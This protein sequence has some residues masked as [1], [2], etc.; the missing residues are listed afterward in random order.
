MQVN[1]YYSKNFK[2]K[3]KFQEFFVENFFFKDKNNPMSGKLMDVF[4]YSIEEFDK[5][6]DTFDVILVDDYLID[7]IFENENFQGMIYEKWSLNNRSVAFIALSENYNQIKQWSNY[8]N[9]IRAYDKTELL[10]FL[11]TEIAHDILRFILNE[12]KLKIFISHAKKDGKYIA[13]LMKEFIDSDL[14]LSNFFD[15]VDIQNSDNWQVSLKENIKDKLF[16]YILT[17]SYGHTKWTKQELIWAKELKVPIIGVDVVGKIN[18]SLIPY[19]S[20]TKLVKLTQ[21]VKNIELICKDRFSFLTKHNIRTVINELLKTALEYYLFQKKY[22]NND[23][24]TL[25]RK[26][27]LFD[28][29]N[30][31]K[32]ILYPDPPMMIVEKEV[33]EKCSDKK[34]FTPLTKRIKNTNKKI[35]ISISESPDLEEKGMSIHHLNL[36]MIEIA[37]YLIIQNNTLIYGGDLGYKKEFNF[38]EK[39]AE[40]FHSYNK[41]FG[42]DKKIVNYAAYPFC[43]KINLNIRN[44]FRNVIQFNE[45]IGEDCGF[46]EIDKITKN[47]TKMREII[48]EKMDIKVALGGKITGFS[49][50]YPGVLEEVYLALKSGKS[51][52]LIGGF[53]GIV[54]KIVE[55]LKGYNVEELT[56]EYQKT[57]NEKLD[58][59]LK[60]NPKYE[61]EIKN[62]Y[63]EMYHLIQNFGIK[64]LNNG[65]E[66]EENEKLF[67]SK[68]IDEI[69]SLILKGVISYKNDENK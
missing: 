58:K 32:D 36:A 59:F 9:F 21:E 68:S 5:N 50:F 62:K 24:L 25:C 41:T 22:N 13:M 35:A 44:K 27:D 51:V 69:V 20:N 18:E 4:Y 53:G 31:D 28:L 54:A 42:K 11:Y 7:E 17:D 16:L 6:S 61:K 30:C 60:D 63:N 46:D 23:Y 26:P 1:I 52:F 67:E 8:I 39:L 38:T 33:I 49:G 66:E 19:I 14:K 56:F 64:S 48:N 29:C 65:L 15:E 40:L 2:E 55:L 10:D 3:T 47:L 37:R 34:L 43:K 57:H 45:C 12:Y